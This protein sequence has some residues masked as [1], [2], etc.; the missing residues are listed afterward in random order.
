MLQLGVTVAGVII[1]VIGAAS[2]VERGRNV[3]AFALCVLAV[4]LMVAG[5]SS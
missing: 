1:I 4:L 2:A 5:I 3:L